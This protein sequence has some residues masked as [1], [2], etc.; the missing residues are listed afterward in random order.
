MP[1]EERYITFNLDEIYRAVLMLCK[2]QGG[3]KLQPPPLGVPKSIEFDK[4][5][6]EGGTVICLTVVDA[7][8][9]VRLEFDRAF[10]V[11]ALVLLCQANSI[12]LP[13]GGTKILK[14]L[15]N[16]IIMK[17]NLKSALT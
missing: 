13:R 10:F 15:E 3:V 9:D 16:N 11:G 17:I 4:H 2:S 1:L 7:G 14:V 8:L 12:P 5:D 6:P